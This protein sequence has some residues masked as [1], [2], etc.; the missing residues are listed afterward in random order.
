[1]AGSVTFGGML[2]EISSAIAI[3]SEVKAKVYL[4]YWD[5]VLNRR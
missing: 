3:V 4:D 5:G 2:K 1:M